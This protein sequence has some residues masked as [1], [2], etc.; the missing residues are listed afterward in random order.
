[1]WRRASVANEHRFRQTTRL[2]AAAESLV[3]PLADVTPTAATVLARP[4]SIDRAAIPRRVPAWL[5]WTIAAAATVALLVVR[6]GQVSDTQLAL[7]DVVTGATEMAT[8]RLGDGTVV[9]LA[10]ASRLRVTARAADGQRR[11]DLDGR[12]FFVVAKQPHK[13]FVV[14]TTAGD[15]RVLGTRF[16]L[17]ARE[18]DLHLLVVEGRVALSA[19]AETVEVHGGEESGVHHNSPVEPTK[20]ADADRM[21]EWVGRFLAFQ[22]TPIRDAAREIERMYSVHIRP[23]STIA[24]R[25]ISAVFTDRTVTQVLDILCSVTDAACE[26]RA[27]TTIMTAKR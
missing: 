26:S 5:P 7:G 20:V 10:P 13:P 22:A 2:L 19:G 14:H 1:V 9:R 25:T 23:D 11:V 3:P 17:A 18:T 21:E 8:V 4:R 12:A 16:E 24:G 15:A 6:R 27:D